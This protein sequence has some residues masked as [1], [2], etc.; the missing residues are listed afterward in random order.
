[1]LPGFSQL[2]GYVGMMYGIYRY[3]IFHIKLWIE[4]VLYFVI[5]Q[6]YLQLPGFSHH[7][8]GQNT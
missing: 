1:M 3:L 8:Y 6:R 2:V 5:N 7:N 4:H